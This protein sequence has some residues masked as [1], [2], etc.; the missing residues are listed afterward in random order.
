MRNSLLYLQ[1]ESGGGEG[2]DGGGVDVAYV[3][4]VVEVGWRLVLVW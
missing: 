4:V 2:R 3:A 1:G